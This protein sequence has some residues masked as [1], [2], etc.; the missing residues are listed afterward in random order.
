[1]EPD[2][3][4]HIKALA[5]EAGFSQV[6][7]TTV[8]PCPQANARFDY[9]LGAG[10]HGE[11]DYLVRHREKRRTPALLLQGAR[12]AI[13]VALNYYQ[14]AEAVNGRDKRGSFSI[15]VHGQDYHDVMEH[16]LG[17]LD[18]R[19]RERYPGTKTVACVDTAPVSDRS[20]AI[21]SG[22]AWLGKNSCAISPEYGSW[23]FLG[24]LI[25]DLDLRADP[26]LETSCGECTRC[27]DACP[28]GAL[29]EPFLVDARKCISYLTIEERGEIPAGLQERIGLSVFGCDTCQRVCPFNDVAK[30][31]VV[32]D[33]GKGT[34]LIDV[35][36]D[37][38]ATISDDRF[39]QVTA[40]SA[41]R[42][43]G[44]ERLRRNAGIVRNNIMK[45][46]LT[47]P[48]GKPKT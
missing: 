32:F 39:D 24:E 40:N 45:G 29:A 41:V 44:P 16:M 6:G 20:M 34:P 12:S 43:C 48:A 35:P 47:R 38:L 25:T 10:M 5:V 33:R 37:E 8:T 7:I 14:N 27:I 28:T 26:P 11:M 15:Y 42:R 21:K 1:M 13:C 4:D 9:W 2:R 18:A 19:L 46:N 31:S 17:R 3:E 22:I 23:I 36:V 30:D